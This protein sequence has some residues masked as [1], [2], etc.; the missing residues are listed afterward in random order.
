MEEL[1]EEKKQKLREVFVLNQANQN[2]S[3]EDHLQSYKK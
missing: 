2:M 1:V 3:A